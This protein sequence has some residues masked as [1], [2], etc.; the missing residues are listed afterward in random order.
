MSKEIKYHFYLKDT[1]SKVPTPII[2]VFNKGSFRRKIGV[3]EKM[4]PLWWDVENECAIEDSRQ[5]KAEKALAK[6]VNRNLARLREELDEL[7]EEYNG[8]DKLTPNHTDGEDL[9]EELFARAAAIIGGKVK[10]NDDEDKASR[11][12]PQ[13]VL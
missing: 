5:K 13:R 6:R 2:F 4:L 9:L 10:A 1:K 11:K 12:T 7:F 8:V 3:G